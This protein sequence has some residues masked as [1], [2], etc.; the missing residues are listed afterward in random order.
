MKSLV[1]SPDQFMIL[2]DDF[3]RQSFNLFYANL[4]FIYFLKLSENLWFSDVFRGIEIKHLGEIGQKPNISKKD[5]VLGN[6]V[7][8][9]CYVE[10]LNLKFWRFV[11][12][13][14]S[15]LLYHNPLRKKE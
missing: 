1:W 14:K 15:L 2:A 3:C 12:N 9:K 11:I 4:L 8:L 13:L 10:L 7:V 6:F 5:F